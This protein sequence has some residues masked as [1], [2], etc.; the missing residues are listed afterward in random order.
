MVLLHSLVVC[1]WWEEGKTGSGTMSVCVNPKAFPN[2]HITAP[3]RNLNDFHATKDP[4]S[5]CHYQ[6]GH[7]GGDYWGDVTAE[8]KKGLSTAYDSFKTQM[9]YAHSEYDDDMDNDYYYDD[10]DCNNGT[11]SVNT[12]S[13]FCV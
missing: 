3:R 10:D 6:P 1:R 4:G 13:L 5:V 9:N 2:V 7:S 12:N 8:N 11:L